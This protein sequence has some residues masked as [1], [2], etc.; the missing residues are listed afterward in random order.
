MVE[1]TFPLNKMQLH[2]DKTFVLPF[3]PCSPC[4]IQY[5]QQCHSVVVGSRCA[6]LSRSVHIESA[7]TKAYRTLFRIKKVFCSTSNYSVKK[8]LYLSLVLPIISYGSPIWRHS[9]LKHIELIEKL[10]KRATEFIHL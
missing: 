2:E 5:K 1:W 7:L 10:Q 4:V 6:D 3:H 8:S 9:H